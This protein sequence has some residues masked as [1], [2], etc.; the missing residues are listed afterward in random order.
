MLHGIILSLYCGNIY[1]IKLWS[2]TSYMAILPKTVWNF[3]CSC[4]DLPLTNIANA[5]I[6]FKIPDECH[7]GLWDRDMKG[8]VFPRGDC[9]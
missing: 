7:W 4:L 6:S 8:T 3:K 1:Y 5:E 2:R 9:T